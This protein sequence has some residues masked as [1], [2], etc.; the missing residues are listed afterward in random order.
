MV[1]FETYH[2]WRSPYTSGRL[3]TVSEKSSSNMYGHFL[4]TFWIFVFCFFIILT[5]SLISKLKSSK[6]CIFRSRNSSLLSIGISSFAR[7]SSKTAATA[8]IFKGICWSSQSIKAVRRELLVW[9]EPGQIWRYGLQ[10]AKIS[11]SRISHMTYSVS[12]FKTN[13]STSRKFSWHPVQFAIQAPGKKVY[14]H[15]LCISKPTRLFRLL[16]PGPE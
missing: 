5:Y 11:I 2:R 6:W 3:F 15:R 12:W 10:T 1:R 7:I 16:Q 14:A 9:K 8:A 13:H 4:I